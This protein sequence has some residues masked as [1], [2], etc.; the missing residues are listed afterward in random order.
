MIGIFKTIYPLIKWSVGVFLILGTLKFDAFGSDVKKETTHPTFNVGYQVLDFKHQKD[1]KKQDLT[2]AVW[3]PT[4]AQPKPYNYGGPTNGHIAVDAAPLSETGPYPLLVFSHGYGGCGLS[5]VFFTE[6]LA[7]RGWIVVA[8]DHHDRYSATRIRSGQNQ[9]F[10]RLGFLR[11]AKE[12]AS[13]SPKDREKYLYRLDEM[14][15]ALD[16][17]SR[18]SLFGKLIDKNRI[19]VGGH[20][21]GGFTALGLCGTIKE[22][23]DTRIK[24]VLL[25]STGAGG[26]LFT[27][28]E[29][30]RVRIPSMLFMG[31]RE[32]QQNRGAKTMSEISEKIYTNMPTPKYFLEIKG[33]NHFSFNNRFV[34]DR[35]TGLLSGNEEMFTVIRQYSIAFLGNHVAGKKN[36]GSVLNRKDPMLTRYDKD[37][38]S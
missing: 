31:E 28:D 37:P 29:L 10:D 18:H 1:G 35:M 5:A 16:S 33:A 3:Y 32:R 12:I 30:Q 9:E 34:D 26:Y 6:Q 19:A 24:A 20:S 7:A 11:H 21:F 38:G 15:L 13:S 27:E 17:I 4:K 22:W 36:S 14:R 25:F 8:P 2:V 23:H